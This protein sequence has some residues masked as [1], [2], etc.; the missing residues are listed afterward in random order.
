[1]EDDYNPDDANAQDEFA[2][3]VSTLSMKKKKTMV[4]YPN[5]LTQEE[6]KKKLL[7]Y[8]T[9]KDKD[10]GKIIDD[11]KDEQA[12]IEYTTMTRLMKY[13]GHWAQFGVLI[14]IQ[15]TLTYFGGITSYMIGEWAED[16]SLQF[17]S[18]KFR[19][20]VFKIIAI[21]FIQACS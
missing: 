11:E 15:I 8:G 13:Y 20:H 7:Q 16:K 1:M 3:N 19:S 2:K 9:I 18:T 14:V 17:D 6:K 10:E 5:G 4:N 12:E 21:V